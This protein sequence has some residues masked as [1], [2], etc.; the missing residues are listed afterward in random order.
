MKIWVSILIFSVFLAS[1]VSA[2]AYNLDIKTDKSDY[3]PGE[4]MKFTVWLLEGSNPVSDKCTVYFSDA[5]NNRMFQQSVNANVENTLEIGSNFTSGYWTIK[6]SYGEKNV[7]RIFMV[8]EKENVILS[9]E[10][11]MLIVKNNGNVPYTR[12][13]QILVGDKIIT[14][15]QNIGAGETKEIKIL[16]PEGTY[17]VEITDGEQRITKQEVQLTG[18]AIGL[19]DKDLADKLPIFGGARDL[20][21]K[22]NNNGTALFSVAKILPAMLF[23]AAIAVLGVLSAI[24]KRVKRNA[25]KN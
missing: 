6:T 16:A 11:D 25:Y 20:A 4:Q 23:V 3:S 21:D 2:Q 10:N 14:E 7:T 15:E 8:K 22:E 9:I 1:V 13:I 12:T 19:M 24:Q 17:N 5:I 18:N